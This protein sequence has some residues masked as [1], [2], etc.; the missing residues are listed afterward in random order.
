MSRNPY[1]AHLPT[2]RNR[3]DLAFA[4]D[5]L[6]QILSSISSSA[7]HFY[8]PSPPPSPSA[9]TSSSSSAAI[10]AVDVPSIPHPLHIQ[11]YVERH[12]YR[13][14][15]LLGNSSIL[16]LQFS[17]RAQAMAFLIELLRSLQTEPCGCDLVQGCF[18]SPDGVVEDHSGMAPCY[19]CG[20]WFAEQVYCRDEHTM[21]LYQVDGRRWHEQAGTSTRHQLTEARVRTWLEQVVAT[22]GHQQQQQTQ[23][24]QY[25][26]HEHPQPHH[27]QQYLPHCQHPQPKRASTFITEVD[28]PVPERSASAPASFMIPQEILDPSCR[29]PGFRIRSKKDHPLSVTP[30][31]SSS[32]LRFCYTSERFKAAFQESVTKTV[33]PVCSP[34]TELCTKDVG[35]TAAEVKAKEVAS[36]QVLMQVD[37]LI[38]SDPEHAVVSHYTPVDSV[39][40]MEDVVLVEQH[41]EETKL[42]KPN[43]MAS[44][45]YHEDT[46]MQSTGPRLLLEQQ[47]QE[48]QQGA[49]DVT[50]S[51]RLRHKDSMDRLWMRLRR[52]P[53]VPSFSE[54]KSRRS[55]EGFLE[56]HPAIKRMRLESFPLIKKR[57]SR[58]ALA[59]HAVPLSPEQ[60][61]QQQQESLAHASTSWNNFE[62]VP[63]S[64]T[65][66]AT[67][68]EHTASPQPP[69]TK[70]A[71]GSNRWSIVQKVLTKLSKPGSRHSRN[72]GA[73]PMTMDVA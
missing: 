56:R 33:A 14:H 50:S 49:S 29:S 20:E 57:A 37:E 45:R 68:T 24:T 18:C 7:R 16:A 41:A 15:S 27:P 31:S 34:S 65:T 26:S 51:R 21:D 35:E 8:Y 62:P 46:A 13:Q 48:Q 69:M 60:Q 40:A 54:V 25:A 30:R 73:V 32:S 64:Q 71:T 9:F 55:E 10:A 47:K 2:W 67:T 38:L 59:T 6:T 23:W 4:L 63:Q 42:D 12:L 43:L 52:L 11:R 44:V 3:Q 72:H 19:I 28:R 36:I 39:L 61:Q 53:S 58:D 22:T 17:T 5:S 66:P 70:P 1:F